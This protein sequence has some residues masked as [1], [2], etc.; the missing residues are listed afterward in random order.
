MTGAARWGPM[1]PIAYVLAGVL[2]ATMLAGAAS[3]LPADK[4]LTLE[5]DDGQGCTSDQ[6]ADCFH[7]TNGSLDGFE[8]GMRV[9]IKLE[10]V[11]DNPHNVFA[12]KGSD[13]DSNN[14]DTGSD[15]AINGSET[16]DSGESTNLTF[17][18]PDDAEGLYLWCE[19][20]GHETLGMWLEATVE[21]A[22]NGTDGNAT[23][24]DGANGTDGNM[25]GEDD[26]NGMPAPSALVLTAATLAALA[27]RRGS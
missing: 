13:A 5:A 27:R 3:A 12:A 14:V 10:N 23:G 11:G 19:V 4:H 1:R 16:I 24:E 9:H 22:T 2:L 26:E 25:T 20:Q 17:T 15:A 18:I 21:P 6:K 8:R 7:V